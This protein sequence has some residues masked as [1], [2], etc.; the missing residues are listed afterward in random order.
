M[1]QSKVIPILA[2]ALL[3]TAVGAAAEEA[4]CK[5]DDAAETWTTCFLRVRD[6]GIEAAREKAKEKAVEDAAAAVARKPNASGTPEAASATKDYLR[7]LFGA[8][9]IGDLSEDEGS[10]TLSINLSP[11]TSAA[12]VLLEVV[13]RDGVLFEAMTEAIPEAIRS[14]RKETLKGRLEDFDDLEAKISFNL[15]T[16]PFG[17]NLL[18]YSTASSTLFDE[19]APDP[20]F[21]PMQTLLAL[22]G[23]LGPGVTMD[24]AV[25]GNPRADEIEPRVL[26]AARQ[27][28]QDALGFQTALERHSYFRLADLVSNQPQLHFE[29]SFRERDDLV[30]PD[31]WGVK[32]TYEHGF[33][34]LNGA[35]KACG[36]NLTKDDEYAGKTM[37]CYEKF[38]AKNEGKIKT[39]NRL[40]VSV[41]YQDTDP[42]RFTLPDDGFLFELDSARKL[43]GSLTWGRSLTVDSKGEDSSRFDVE[44]KYEDVTGDEMRNNRFVATATY[45]LRV[46][47][48]NAFTLGLIYANKPEFLG[49][50]DQELGARFGLKFKLDKKEKK[51]D[52]G[53]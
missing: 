52:T 20:N 19:F 14:A 38:L 11:T 23:S 10:Q 33:G 48:G 24:D 37:T 7:R 8:L 17:R 28:A 22:V 1:K 12:P 13:R 43:I 44:A 35:L 42:Y 49:E 41:E 51:G 34:S 47:D 25:Q 29:L 9:G 53:K 26:A 32:A 45:T 15:E 5:R 21:V 4:A 6:Q 39:S 31:A 3:L 50:V 27:A 36:Q 18:R 46:L 16:R 30:G 2:L 40:A